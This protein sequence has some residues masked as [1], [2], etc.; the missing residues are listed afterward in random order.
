M[1]AV[2]LSTCAV[3]LAGIFQKHLIFLPRVK[4]KNE[5]FDSLTHMYFLKEKKFIE[6]K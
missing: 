5:F 6:Q 2:E 1:E 3:M 4:L